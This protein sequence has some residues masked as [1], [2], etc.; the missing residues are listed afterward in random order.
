MLKG[1][2]AIVT[3]STSWGRQRH[4]ARGR[5]LRA[6]AELFRH[7]D[8]ADA[9]PVLRRLLDIAAWRP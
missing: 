6:D 5:G 1:K 9:L 4:H 3:R 7:P 8:L 2:T